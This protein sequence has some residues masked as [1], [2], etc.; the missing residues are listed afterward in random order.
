[1]IDY[2]KKEKSLGDQLVVPHICNRSWYG[3]Y[4][5]IGLS[6][7]WPSNTLNDHPSRAYLTWYVH[8][9][10]LPQAS[11]SSTRSFK[12]KFWEVNVTSHSFSTAFNNTNFSQSHS[13]Y[14]TRG[15]F[16]Q[17]NTSNR[18]LTMVV[19]EDIVTPPMHAPIVKF[20]NIWSHCFN[21]LSLF[22]S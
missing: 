7:V 3:S 13:N 21:L 4:I 11:T 22:W 14:Q 18:V 9:L 8:G 17:F 1:M 20:A 2:L 10:L 5:F 12:L 16:N 19:V 15:S 6:L